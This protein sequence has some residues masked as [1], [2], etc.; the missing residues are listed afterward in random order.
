[1]MKFI[2]ENGY[3]KT[4]VGVIP[5]EWEVSP[6]ADICDILDYKRKPIKAS[7]R[8][9]GKFPYYGASGIIDWVDDYLFDNE[10]I[11]L[12]EDGANLMTRNSPLAFRV[13]GK[14]WVNNHAHV[15][16]IASN[17]R[18]NIDF[19]T[20]VLESKD[21]LKIVVGSAQ[22]KITQEQ[23]AAISLQRPP[24]HE[25]KKIADI[26]STVDEHINETESLIEKT[27]TL[28]QGMMQRLLT[29]GI[30][31]TEFKD[32][33]IGRI[34]VVWEVVPLASIA[35]IINGDRGRNYP[36][37]NDMMGSGIPFVNAGHLVNGRIDFASMN[38]ISDEK[39]RHLSSGKFCKG[40]TIYCL[41]GTLGKN[42][43]V[44]SDIYGAIASSLVIFRPNEKICSYYLYYFCNSDLEL[45][46]RSKID[47][48][49]AQPNLSA[50]NV[51]R[52]SLPLPPL[53][54]QHKIASILTTIDD[55]IDTY[56]TKLSSLTH[57]KT[58]LMQQL[59][60]GKI[61]VKV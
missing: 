15:F 34:P 39:F 52:Y 11:L 28:K 19:V 23:C 60:T 18:D 10:L 47:T 21:Y 29:K 56:Q 35:K 49:S 45:F 58:G 61:R 7:E 48:G 4:E 30:G 51:G 53:H 26:L 1:M 2:Y 3:K 50:E 25:Q 42:A 37:K 9:A 44:T 41:R 5:E 8:K 13:S 14:C 20:M 55:Q 27:K 31:H 40:D 24:L 32:T 22:P 59:L 38:Y 6:L 16:Q 57:I 36:S 54:E 43:L 33:E 17:R 12:G 46:Q